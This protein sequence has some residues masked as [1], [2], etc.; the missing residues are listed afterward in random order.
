MIVINLLKME[1]KTMKLKKWLN[2]IVA[3]LSALLGALGSQAM[4]VMH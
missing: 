4:T 1:D 3:V 2:V